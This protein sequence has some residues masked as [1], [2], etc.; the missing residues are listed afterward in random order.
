MDLFCSLIFMSSVTE[1]QRRKVGTRFPLE[2]RPLDVRGPLPFIK[3][4]NMQLLPVGR[5]FDNL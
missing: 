4:M 1:I 2:S 3:D 5:D